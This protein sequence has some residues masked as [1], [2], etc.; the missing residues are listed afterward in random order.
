MFR[1]PAKWIYVFRR[2]S[3]IRELHKFR[4]RG[5]RVAIVSDYPAKHKLESLAL[6][7]VVEAVIASG[8]SATYQLKPRGDAYAAAAQLLGV[9]PRDCLVV[10]DRNDTDGVAARH[11]NMDFRRI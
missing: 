8:E 2:R 5:G 1:R 4:A 6:S 3:L 9:D 10:G 11:A 7:Q